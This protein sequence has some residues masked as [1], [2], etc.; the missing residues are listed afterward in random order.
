[1][2]HSSMRTKL[3]DTP[4]KNKYSINVLFVIRMYTQQLREKAPF[5]FRQFISYL[6]YFK[7]SQKIQYFWGYWK[8]KSTYCYC[9]HVHIFRKHY[10]I[11]QFHTFPNTCV[12]LNTWIDMQIHTDI[13]IHKY[14]CM[15]FKII[16]I[17]F[18][19]TPP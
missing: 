11:F 16:L 19:L 14:T 9:Y 2:Q 12:K 7:Y 5:R 17:C 1:M 15:I 8:E 3:H 10:H 13:Y 6:R 18:R 4:K